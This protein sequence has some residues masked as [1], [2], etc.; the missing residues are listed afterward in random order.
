VELSLTAAGVAL[1]CLLFTLGAKF[2][3]VMNISEMSDV[4]KTE[5]MFESEE[6]LI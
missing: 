6:S 4:P 3:P 1:F 5:G 2:V